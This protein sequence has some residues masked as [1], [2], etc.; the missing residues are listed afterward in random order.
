M[1]ASKYIKELKKLIDEY[2]DLEVCSQHYNP[3]TKLWETGPCKPDFWFRA[4]GDGNS[5]SC[6]GSIWE[7]LK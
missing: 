2:G 3:E 5:E 7:D 6:F 4:T 1:K